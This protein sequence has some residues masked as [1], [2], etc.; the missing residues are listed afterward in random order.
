MDINEFVKLPVDFASCGSDD[1][2]DSTA[3]FSDDEC[4]KAE[5]YVV[6]TVNLDISAVFA[7]ISS[8]T[9]RNGA[10]Y[11]YASRLLNAQ[12]ALER[13]KPA[14]PPL[15]K[16]IKGFFIIFSITFIITINVYIENGSVVRFKNT[17]MSVHLNY[18]FSLSEV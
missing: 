16:A 15:L 6:D 18:L 1:I 8:L 4:L 10:N 17:V 9:H 11:D 5:D 2:Y 7:L 12:A 3:S 13:K 14:L